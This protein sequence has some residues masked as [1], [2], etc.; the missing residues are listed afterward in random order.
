VRGAQGPDGINVDP[1]AGSSVN[2]IPIAPL[3]G[4]DSVLSHLWYG[5]TIDSPNGVITY[6]F[7]DTPGLTGRYNAPHDA[8]YISNDPH[9]PYHGAYFP[10]QDAADGYY[11]F[12]AEQ[13]AAARS[14][15]ELWD[16]LIPQTFVETNGNGAD[17]QFANS[18]D[19][20]QAY[21]TPPYWSGHGSSFQGDVFTHDPI[22]N[23]SN[24]EF[25]F[26][27]YGATTLIHEIGH[28]LGL[29]HPGNYNYSDD[30]DGD[31]QP[32]PIT[33][34]ND[35]EYFQDS[36]EYTIMSYFGAWNTGG[37]PIDWRYSGG[38]FYDSS[39]QGPMLHDIFAIQEAY[40]ADPTTRVGETTYGFNSNAGNALFDF[41]ENSLP[42]YAIYDAGGQDTIDLSGFTASQYLNLN[43]G[44]FSSI[45]DVMLT[46]EEFGAAFHDGYLA[47]YGADL[48]DY[49]YTDTEL[50][51]IALGGLADTE[52]ANAAAILADTGV[53]GIATV[54]YETVAIAYGTIIENAVGGQGRDLIIGNDVDNRIDGQG[55]D[56]ILT[57]GAGR[58]V[59]V[60]DNNGST[61]TITDF[62]SG[63]D[64]I[65]LS[66]LS[67]VGAA[68]VSYDAASHMV[69]IDTNHDGLADMFIASTNTVGSGD[70]LFHIG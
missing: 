10:G 20:A 24:G 11:P 4:E 49:G 46:T 3:T 64:S 58:D 5:V 68:D 34:A 2:G 52:A 30:N 37:A 57:G 63:F 41:N 70:Y 55:G 69:Q 67:G 17:I 8:G 14:A 16:D 36:Q 54:N 47:G 56:D 9:N 18:L 31:G 35:A 42:Y 1:Y 40:G 65:D 7:A 66:H 19:P 26:G 25:E 23:P 39:P 29:S 61:D 38:I 48:Y 45:G 12:T 44:E 60:F 13:Q 50:G 59:F 28:T 21:A 51:S 15:I 27:Q 22:T 53:S 6:G 33:Y 43:A 32:D 62:Q